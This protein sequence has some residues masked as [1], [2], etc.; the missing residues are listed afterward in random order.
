[1]IIDLPETTTAAVNATLVDLRRRGGAV[2][3]GRVLTLIVAIPD[4]AAGEVEA[5]VRAANSASHAHPCRVIV[6]AGNDRTAGPRVD[7]QIRVGG[8]AGASEVIVLR[9]SGPLADQPQ[10]IVEPLLLPDAPIVTWWPAA[11]PERPAAN[12][13]GALAQRRI[14]DASA[15]E[16]PIRALRTRAKQYTPGDTDLAW[17]RLTLWRAQLAAALDLPPHD[18]VVR[19]EV[20]GERRSPSTEL[21]AAWL[22]DSLRVPVHRLGG[23]RGITSVTLERVSGPITLN[24]PDG[25]TA[26]LTQPGCPPRELALHRREIADVLVEEL[27]RLDPDEIYERTLRGLDLLH[28]GQE[29]PAR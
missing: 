13:L 3:L 21:L 16:D 22:A 15:D 12:P 17:T 2:T 26:T 1:M 14:T 7:G 29:A 24:R 20:T 27:R 23:G 5:A 6:V 8:D 19:A 28:T 25:K 10:T 11:A 4:D 9:L 18:P